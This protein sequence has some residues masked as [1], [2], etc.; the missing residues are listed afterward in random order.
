MEADAAETKECYLSI[1]CSIKQ[2]GLYVFG[3]ADELKTLYIPFGGDWEP[4]YRYIYTLI[5]GGGYDDQGKPILT[6]IQFESDVEVWK[7]EKINS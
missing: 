2:K 5:F 1:E 3:S 7:D 6:P 4:G